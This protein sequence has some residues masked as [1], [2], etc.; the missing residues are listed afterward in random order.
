LKYARDQVLHLA[1]VPDY[2]AR[3]P[4]L[5]TAA[6]PNP[7]SF[8]LTLKRKFQFWQH[9]PGNRVHSSLRATLRANTTKDSS[10]FDDDPFV[11]PS[12]VPAKTGYVSLALQGSLS[13]GGVSGTIG[14]L[15]FGF[16]PNASIA[17]EY[18]KA[19]PLGKGEPT[20][21]GA[22]GKMISGFVIPADVDDLNLL[23]LNDVS[24]VSGQGSLTVSAAFNVS[25]I[26]NPLASVA[27]PLNAGKIDVKAGAMAG[28][29]GSFSIRGSYQ[30]R[31]R[32]HLG[33]CR[34]AQYLQG[35]RNHPQCGSIC[36]G[37]CGREMG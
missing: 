25:A 29:T 1:V 14:D 8:Q 18:W 34:R 9:D 28:I 12:T 2:L 26:P 4:Q 5:L 35:P 30:V 24:T 15:T 17:L 20:L 16:D 27:L 19:F 11:V 6:A 37:R 10:L 3:A 22:T 21:G 7:I 33:R 23:A 32:P 31:V 13:L 36:L